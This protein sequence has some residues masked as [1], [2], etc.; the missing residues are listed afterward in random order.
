MTSYMLWVYAS[1]NE[2]V[3]MAILMEGGNVLQLDAAACWGEGKGGWCT[4]LADQN[5]LR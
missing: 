5:V 4:R 2:F 1:F 3:V